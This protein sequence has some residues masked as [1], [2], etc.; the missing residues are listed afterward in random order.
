MI[1]LATEI[2]DYMYYMR[3]VYMTPVDI[4]KHK[5]IREQWTLPEHGNCGSRKFYTPPSVLTDVEV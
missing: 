4:N 2:G 1:A 5:H 3:G